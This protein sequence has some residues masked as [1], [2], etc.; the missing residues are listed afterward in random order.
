MKITILHLS[1][2]TSANPMKALLILSKYLNLG[3]QEAKDIVNSFP[4][5]LN[6]GNLS[7]QMQKEL[8]ASLSSCGIQTIE[9]PLPILSCNDF[10]L[11]SYLRDLS[12]LESQ[13][14][15]CQG[16]SKNESAEVFRTL[17]TS[18]LDFTKTTLSK[19]Y[20]LNVIALKY[21]HPIPVFQFLDYL[22]DGRCT[23]LE[24][25]KEAYALYESELLQQKI[26]NQMNRI[27]L[28]FED[29]AHAQ[30]HLFLALQAAKAAETSKVTEEQ[31]LNRFQKMKTDT[32]NI[33]DKCGL[34]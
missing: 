29:R 18:Q 19:L 16:I 26:T 27:T 23:Q 12:L 20:S 21:R 13:I 11:L 7:A 30:Y 3:M 5:D 9:K 15:L 1:K 25:E 6:I 31:T 28:H 10:E 24:G 34:S 17:Y 22:E 32:Q 8:T 2:S 33:L 14:M 4:T